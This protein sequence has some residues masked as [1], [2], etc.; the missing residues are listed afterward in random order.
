VLADLNDTPE[1]CGGFTVWLTAKPR[2]WLS[3]RYI[4]ASWD[5]KVLEEKRDDVVREDKLKVRLVI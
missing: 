2:K 3:G 1:L 5:V 4:A